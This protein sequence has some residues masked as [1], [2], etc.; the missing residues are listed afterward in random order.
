MDKGKNTN[1]STKIGNKLSKTTVIE[2]VSKKDSDTPTKTTIKTNRQNSRSLTVKHATL[3]LFWIATKRWYFQNRNN[4]KITINS[5]TF[6]QWPGILILM[7]INLNPIRL[8]RSILQVASLGL[9]TKGSTYK[10]FLILLI[11]GGSISNKF[12]SIIVIKI[13]LKNPASRY[14]NLSAHFS[15]V[16][17]KPMSCQISSQR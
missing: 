2:A 6:N 9:S 3:T 14:R 7:K 10:V 16:T 11:I 17:N 4:A 5:P 1:T 12:M 13:N 15:Q 8:G